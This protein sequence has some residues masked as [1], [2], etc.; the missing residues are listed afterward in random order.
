MGISPAMVY[1][2]ADRN[3]PHTRAGDEAIAIGASYLDIERIVGAAK[4]VGA[5][6]I[7]P[8]YG[9][10]SENAGF[11]EACQSAG[12]IFIGPSPDVIRKM[13]LKSSAR[14]LAAS[15][16]VPVVPGDMQFP[17]IIKASAGGGGRGMRIVRDPN[18]FHEAFESARG[19]AERTFGDGPML[20]E[21]YIE[22][23]RHVEVQL[24]GDMHGN[25]IPPFQPHSSLQPPP[26][27]I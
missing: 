17:V 21:R 9:F 14:E 26:P 4:H 24:F 25:P 19:E 23:A 2:D 13:G 8:G 1:T 5:D 16:G 3:A 18:Q 11:A 15:T 12:L 6:A 7:H 22:G 27:N 10:L 20:V